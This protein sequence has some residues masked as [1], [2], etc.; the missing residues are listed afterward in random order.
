MSGGNAGPTAGTITNDM[1]WQTTVAAGTHDKLPS[2]SFTLGNG[3]TYTGVG[4]AGAVPSAPLVDA[5]QAAA[6][7]QTA[8]NANLCVQ[9][10]LD[11]A[12]VTGAIVL[13]QRGG[14]GRLQ[15]SAA[16]K[17]AGGVGMILWNPTA[18]GLIADFHSIPTVHVDTATG[19]AVRAY[20][21]GTTNPTASIAATVV[22]TVE[23][24]AVTDFSSRGPTVNSAGSLIKPDITAPGNDVIAG[25][26]P[27]NHDGGLYDTESGTSQAAPHIAGLA[28]LLLA[29]H[30]DWSP[31]WLK[32]AI[33][34]TAKQKDSDGKPITDQGTGADATPLAM[35]SG[36]V[37][38]AAAFDP[39][40][41]YDSDVT[42]WV[43]FTCGIGIHLA[44]SSGHDACLTTGS[45]SGT[46][47]NYPSIS[48]NALL[49]SQTV[50]RTV[51]NVDRKLGI[52]FP[53]VVAP[54]GYTVSVSPKVL[55]VQPHKTASYTITVNHTDAAFNQFAFG[56]ITWWDL[57]GHKVYSPLAV[58]SV[59][60]SV[61]AAVSGTG[62]TGSVD[63]TAMPAYNGTLA[64][65][66]FGLAA[67]AGVT[68]AL[69]QDDVPFD[70]AHPAAGVSTA[71]ISFTVPTG[72]KLAR[73]STF[74][75]DFAPN[76]DVDLYLYGKSSSGV[77]TALPLA[78]SAGSS[79]NEQISFSTPGNYVV[80]V[81]LFAN[82]AGGTIQV[83]EHQWA[84]PPTAGSLTATPASQSVT[85]ATPATVTLGW[86][87]LTAGSRYLGVVEYNDGT[88]IRGRT[89]V[90]VT[91]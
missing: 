72:T 47:L 36:E 15:K 6:P 28:A 91:G 53:K 62:T 22:K 19:Q 83:P 60:L 43:A 82:P 25:V 8:A 5:A 14:N 59:P 77:L 24:P 27:L 90:T 38:P 73:V 84:V 16:V 55:V 51:T 48:I 17:A 79:A 56:S 42:D 67:D 46:D 18:Q 10:A 33:M 52:Y 20:I 87:D 74:A 81:D 54:A 31:M 71:A 49:N 76:T 32:S 86:T 39:G 12:K 30:P 35:G 9:G 45:I 75:S 29:K 63:V 69:A 3:V 13:C 80:F 34:T 2:K 78:A 58:R 26:S 85:P 4:V 64:A 1:P 61:P 70:R 89:V 37:A 66:P 21:A 41:V 65:Q 7:G 57:A 68:S 50:T 88:T 44:D 40:L 11:P 23:A